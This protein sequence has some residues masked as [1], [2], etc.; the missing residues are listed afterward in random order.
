MG[1][2]NQATERSMFAWAVVVYYKKSEDLRYRD[3]W[4]RQRRLAMHN[5]SVQGEEVSEDEET[6]LT[7]VE[8]EIAP[9]T[10][11]HICRN[12]PNW[13][14]RLIDEITRCNEDEEQ[15]IIVCCRGKS[16]AVGNATM[17]GALLRHQA[18]MRGMHV[19][20]YGIDI[21]AHVVESPNEEEVTDYMIYVNRRGGWIIAEAA[22]GNIVER[23]TDRVDRITR[24]N[25]LAWIL[26]ERSRAWPRLGR[27][28]FQIRAQRQQGQPTLTQEEI[29]QLYHIETYQDTM[30]YEGEEQCDDDT[31]TLEDS[32]EVEMTV[33]DVNWLLDT[34]LSVP[35]AERPVLY[36]SEDEARSDTDTEATEASEDESAAAM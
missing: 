7:A 22:T 20:D 15:E 25:F 23:Y 32:Q 30:W 14:Q 21:E 16:K 12:D 1:T 31:Q 5:I 6:I 27:L 28:Q 35:A 24:W 33:I 4:Q 17:I 10:R 8:A 2:Y 3:G 11:N 26:V 19:S 29:R 18:D 34:V 36:D 13:R 9:P